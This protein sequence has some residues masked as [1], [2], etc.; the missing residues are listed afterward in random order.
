MKILL[1]SDFIFGLVEKKDPHHKFCAKYAIEA[2][3]KKDKFFCLNITLQETATVLSNKSSHKTAVEFLNNLDSLVDTVIVL[4]NVIE[5]KAWKIFKR[6]KKNK[7]SYVDCANLA[8]CEF[9]K[10]D[11]IASFDK[12]YPEQYKIN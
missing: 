12:F 3:N 10:L 7:T 5:N 4:D 1:D 11:K 6:E 8:A 2:N 9:Y